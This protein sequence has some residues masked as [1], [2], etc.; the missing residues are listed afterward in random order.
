MSKHYPDFIDKYIAYLKKEHEGE[1][2]KENREAYDKEL[3]DAKA[4]MNA[5]MQKLKD[6]VE[7]KRIHEKEL[8][9]II[10]F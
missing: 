1:E 8:E 2:V 5:S 10:G 9:R 4:E 3:E 7:A 6:E